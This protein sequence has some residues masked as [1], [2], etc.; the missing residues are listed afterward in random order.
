M[1]SVC[2]RGDFCALAQASN[3][4]D[5][6]VAPRH[7]TRSK[8]TAA[9]GLSVSTL[10]LW[11]TPPTSRVLESSCKSSPPSTAAA[12][13][14]VASVLRIRRSA[15]TDLELAS[16]AP[17]FVCKEEFSSETSVVNCRPR[18]CPAAHQEIGAVRD[19]MVK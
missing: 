19:P 15:R 8:E 14:T 13:A 7:K 6:F 16:V 12:D 9:P 11:A 10:E 3:S 4:A 5:A 2:M 18:K 17:T 1:F